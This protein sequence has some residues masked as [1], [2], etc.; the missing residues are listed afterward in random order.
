M[1]K[2]KAAKKPVK[3]NAPKPVNLTQW[4]RTA[5]ANEVMRMARMMEAGAIKEYTRLAKIAPNPVT[6][7][8]FRYMVEEE[9]QHKRFLDQ[10][11]QGLPKGRPLPRTGLSEVVDIPDG[12]DIAKAIKQSIKN[13]ERAKA[14]YTSAAKRCKNANARNV[15]RTLAMMEKSHASFLREELRS[16]TGNW[17]WSSLEGAV[18]EEEHFWTT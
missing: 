15:L 5:S 11:A 1:A 18:F 12:E 17:G 9:R 14:F 4:L 2:A 16:L 10:L 3:K 6:R 8:K 7:A 13:E